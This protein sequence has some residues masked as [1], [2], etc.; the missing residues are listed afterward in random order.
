MIAPLEGFSA[1]RLNSDNLEKTVYRLGRGPAVVII[2]E[3][4]GMVPECVALARRLAA[5]GFSVY[6]PLLFGEPNKNYGLKPLLW[7]CV[8]REFTLL[9]ARRS[10]PITDWLRALCRR[11]HQE[12]GGPG[13]GAIGM[14]LT[15]GFALGL[16]LDSP[17]LAPVL[18]QPSLPLFNGS[19]LGLSPEELGCAQ[20]RCADE[21]LSVLG[22]RF[23]GDRLCPDGRFA[24]LREAFASRFEALELPGGDHSVLTLHFDRLTEDLQKQVWNKLV[25]FLSR[26]LKSAPTGPAGPT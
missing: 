1:F 15:G 20:R 19:D 23:R 10:S 2:H 24:A 25:G 4:P 3:L 14:C 6:L 18:S 13:V 7:P 11:A 5:E 16:M 8:W 22:L 21:D 26:R 9:R 17:M 12:A